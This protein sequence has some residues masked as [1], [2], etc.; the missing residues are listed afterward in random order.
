MLKYG[1]QLFATMLISLYVWLRGNCQVN[2]V[3]T[4]LDYETEFVACAENNIVLFFR[5]K[6]FRHTVAYTNRHFPDQVNYTYLV[7]M[8]RYQNNDVIDN[9]AACYPTLC[10]QWLSE[11]TYPHRC[12]IHAHLDALNKHNN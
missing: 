8:I 6:Q 4:G 1:S 9:N 5:C 2:T 12:A 10:H 11:T 7:E 3:L